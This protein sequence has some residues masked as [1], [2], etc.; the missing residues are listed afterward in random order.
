MERMKNLKTWL[1]AEYGRGVTLAK[2][3]GV[4]ASF[5][6]RM[7]D[8]S[9]AIPMQHAAAIELFTGGAVKRQDMFPDTWQQIW[10]ELVTAEKT[11]A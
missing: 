7:G 10:P 11:E 2:H 3:L 9:K 5:V 8:G 1:N 6:S 4:P